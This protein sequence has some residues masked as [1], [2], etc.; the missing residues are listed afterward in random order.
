MGWKQQPNRG[1]LVEDDAIIFDILS[2]PAPQ[3]NPMNKP[4]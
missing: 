2:H 3:L 4:T 1:N